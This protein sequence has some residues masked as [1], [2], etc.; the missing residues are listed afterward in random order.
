MKVGGCSEDIGSDR[1]DGYEH[2][3]ISHPKL[4]N[5]M[6]HPQP[7]EQHLTWPFTR[8]QD[9]CKDEEVLES[10]GV[11]VRAHCKCYYYHIPRALFFWGRKNIVP[12]KMPL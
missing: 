10:V 1:L 8:N 4:P 3:G 7:N 5:L 9:L 12:C 11:F 6:S 2:I